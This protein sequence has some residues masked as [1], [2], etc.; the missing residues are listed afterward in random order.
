MIEKPIDVLA[1]SPVRKGKKQKSQFRGD[2]QAFLQSK[3]YPVSV[4]SGSMGAKNIVIGD[5]NSAKYL[6]TA[7]YDTPASIGLPNVLTPCNPFTFILWQILLVGI[8]LAISVVVMIGVSTLSGDVSLGMITW[9]LVYFGMLV[10]LIAGPANK[11][12]AND[13]TSGVVTLLETAIAW[14]ED[15]RNLVCFVLFDQ[16][17]AGLVGSSSYRKAHKKATNDQIVLNMDCV[18]DGNEILLFPMKKLKKDNEKMALL[19]TLCGNRDVKSI[20]LREKGFATYPSDQKH[21]PYGVG[22]AAFN[23][24][25]GVGLY[26]DRIHTARDTILDEENVN[27][28]RDTLLTLADVHAAE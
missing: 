14:P 24:K 28:L 15:K 16:E 17:E 20:S 21:Y 6:I 26:V 5:P 9:Y 4:E 2:V 18:G 3:G 1:Q 27:Y 25:K 23:R 10:L 11:N 8:F 7:H 12:N 22:I 13:N 19:R